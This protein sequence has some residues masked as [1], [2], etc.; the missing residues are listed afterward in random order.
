MV[1]T[2]RTQ[3]GKKTTTSRTGAPRKKKALGPARKRKS[4]VR[5]T[6]VKPQFGPS[7]YYSAG[8]SIAQPNLQLPSGE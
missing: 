5:F 2:A 3:K 4:T 7:T 6:P 8:Q 1:H